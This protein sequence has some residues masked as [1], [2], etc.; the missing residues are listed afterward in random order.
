MI[1][2]S[3]RP[4]VIL[5]GA[6]GHGKVVA[7]IIRLRAD[8]ALA[9]FIDDGKAAQGIK[10]FDGLPLLGGLQ[11]LLRFLE[12]ADASVIVSVGRNAARKQI[13]DK[14]AQH[15][16]A[17]YTA[18]HP[19]AVVARSARLGRGTV[20][21]AGAVVNP[22]VAIGEHCIINTSCSIDHDCVI[23]DYV[24]VSP[25]A[26]LAGGV[27]IGALS[28]VGIGA[29]I[30]QDIVVGMNATIGAGSVVVTDIPDDVVA[31]GVPATIQRGSNG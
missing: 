27:R 26:H 21:M 15:G 23:E 30:R 10:N 6:S 24:H 2:Q 31:Y 14:L 9:G 28:H 19:A 22:D 20:V 16:A 11:A 3:S 25:G 7:D 8:A 18:V 12:N 1:A 13:A 17:F 29:S 5:Y 4:L